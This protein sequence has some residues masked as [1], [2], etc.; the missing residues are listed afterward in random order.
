MKD[1]DTRAPP[2]GTALEAA[3]PMTWKPPSTWMTSPVIPRESGDRRKSAA[4]PTSIRLWFSSALIE[5]DFPRF[6]GVFVL[7][8]MKIS[9][10]C[11][12]QCG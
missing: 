12:D 4:S 6:L 11:F 10:T 9:V 3:M 7:V 1:R 2:G 8:N 5:T